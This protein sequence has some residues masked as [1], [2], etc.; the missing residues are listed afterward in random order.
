[1]F[2]PSWLGVWSELIAARSNELGLQ[3]M[4]M[5]QLAARLAGGLLRPIDPEVLLQT[6]TEALPLVDMGELQSIKTLPGMPSAVTATF[7]KVW[8]ADVDLTAIEHPRAAALCALEVEVIRRVP[9]SMK[10]PAELV[11]LAIG[12]LTHAA[13]VVGPLEIRGHSEMSPCWRPLLKA[14]TEL[15]PVT[16]IAG[17]RNVPAWLR[18]TRVKIVESAPTR[19]TTV[20]YS[21]AG[22]Q[23]EVIEAFRW[24]RSLLV[25]GVPA[26]DIAIAAASPTDVDDHVFAQDEDSNLL[27]HSV[28]GIKAL[29]TADGQAAAALAEVLGKGL[30]QERVRRLLGLSRRSPA[31][32]DL[33]PEWTRLLPPEAPLSAIGHWEQ[34]LARRAAADVVSGSI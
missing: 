3:I 4:T 1:L 18:Q 8:R 30:S 5:A 24:V 2:T 13:A 23:H 20:S 7:D 28:H 9:A 16:W 6:I 25:K 26:A 14:L 27:V 31:L 22:Q 19:P 32:A 17:P 29:T 33:A 15:V 11:K 12:R 34:A 10:R 21:C